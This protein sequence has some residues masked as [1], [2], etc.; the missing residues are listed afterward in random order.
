MSVKL[1]V[2]PI[3]WS[4]DD[5][6]ELGGDTTLEQCLDEASQAGYIGVENEGSRLSE[7]DGIKATR[8]LLIKVGQSI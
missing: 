1:G 3:A 4:N 6:P 7:I 5:M 2:A 8:D